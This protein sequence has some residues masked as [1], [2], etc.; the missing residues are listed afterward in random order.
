MKP[1]CA[2]RVRLCG[3]ALL[4]LACSPLTAP[5]STL[6]LGDLLNDPAPLGS[7]IVVQSKSPSEKP[8]ALAAPVHGPLVRLAVTGAV[9]SIASPFTSRAVAR[10]LP[11]RI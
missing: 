6:D 7:A 1:T 8:A 10:D 11:L 4:V 5:F 2:L 9:L 3:I